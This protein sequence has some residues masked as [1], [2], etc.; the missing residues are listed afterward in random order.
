MLNEVGTVTEQQQPYATFRGCR[1]FAGRSTPGRSTQ[2]T[3]HVYL[4]EK[5]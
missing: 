4:I 3:E 2:V 1:N 5:D